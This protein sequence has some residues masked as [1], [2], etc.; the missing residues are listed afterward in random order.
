M[1]SSCKIETK[2]KKV[3]IE[4][5][6]KT[7]RLI[8]NK[9]RL[10]SQFENP[11]W[12]SNE[13]C[14]KSTIGIHFDLCQL[15][16][17]KICQQVRESLMKDSVPFNIGPNIKTRN[18]WLKHNS[19]ISSQIFC[20]NTNNPDLILV[21]DGTY[22][23]CERS[24]NNT[25]QRSTYSV[26]KKRHLVKTFVICTTDGFIVDIYGLYEATKNDSSILLD[27]FYTE[28]DLMRLIAHAINKKYKLK[29][30][31]PAFINKNQNQLSTFDA[32]TTRLVT[33]SRYVVE[34]MNAF[35]KKSF[36]AL[37]EVKNKSLT[38]I[39][40]D[41]KIACTLV[42]KFL[43][44]LF[45]DDDYNIEIVNNM[46]RKLNTINELEC[47]IDDFPKIDEQI[48]KN[49]I[50]LGSYQLTQGKSYLAE[51]LNNEKYEIRV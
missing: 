7:F 27:I 49:H 6:L 17:S 23:Y 41:Y 44:R 28:D 31:Y 51:H 47:H 5:L 25:F 24:S 11:L 39:I 29:L 42:N 37:S 8:A 15:E 10:I 3:Y 14:V 50:T 40:D 19:Y 13:F 18:E 30:Q 35:L 2:M 32:I 12:I 38:H 20:D 21:C 45:S 4:P 36:K 1:I 9:K 26:Q 43:K 22:F 34:A 33:K 46:K 16:V 48:I